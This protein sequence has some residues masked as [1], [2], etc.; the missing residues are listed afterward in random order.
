MTDKFITLSAAALLAIV[1]GVMSWSDM[2][3]QTAAR[4]P[5]AGAA[6]VGYFADASATPAMVPNDDR[7]IT[8]AQGSFKYAANG[9]MTFTHQGMTPTAFAQRQVNILLQFDALPKN[10]EETFKKIKSLLEDWKHAGNIVSAV[11][12]DYRPPQPDLA[13]YAKFLQ[14]FRLFAVP[15]AYLLVPVVDL[16]WPAEVNLLAQNGVPYFLADVTTPL[17]PF[18]HKFLLRIPAGVLVP[19]IQHAFFMGGLLTLDPHSPPPTQKDNIGVLPKF[20]RK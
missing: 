10:A 9:Q 16:A 6:I 19:D 11:F 8:I 1:I 13:A 12:F 18:P 17:P 3:P 7:Q 20:L 14:D 2:H 15:D 5:A 4:Q